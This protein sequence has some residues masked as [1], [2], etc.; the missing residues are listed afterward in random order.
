MT[1]AQSP[2]DAAATA[3]GARRGAPARR[4]DLAHGRPE[5]HA[6]LLL[7]RRATSP[8][9]TRRSHT[10]SRCSRPAPTSWTSAASRRAR[11]RVRVEAA[12]EIAARRAGDSGPARR[13]RRPALD[14]H[15]PGRGGARR[16]RR[17]GRPRERRLAA[18][19]STRRWRA[20]WPR[21]GAPAVARCT[22]AATSPRC[23]RAAALR[24]RAWREIAAE[25]REALGSRRARRRRAR[26]S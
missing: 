12:E 14:R 18:S 24:R 4:A 2:C 5:R 17:R 3:Q 26:A 23:T 9:R 8:S 21:A 13:G 20:W 11:L 25:L 22:C 7:R 16:P 19:A 6:R 10:A 1:A 15:D